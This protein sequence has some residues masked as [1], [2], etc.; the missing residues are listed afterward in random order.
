MKTGDM[1]S[2]IETEI[3]AMDQKAWHIIMDQMARQSVENA[4]VPTP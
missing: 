4:P 1:S 2:V 3:M